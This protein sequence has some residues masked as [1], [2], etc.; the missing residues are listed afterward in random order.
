M[1]RR[2]WR[3]RLATGLLLALGLATP[4]AAQN[5]GPTVTN[6][7]TLAQTVSVGG[8]LQLAPAQPVETFQQMDLTADTGYE[9]N[10]TG[11][12]NS[13]GDWLETLAGNFAAGQNRGA[14]HWALRYQPSYTVYRTFRGYDRFDQAGALD[15]SWQLSP[16][17]Y[18]R[19]SEHAAYGRYLA[20]PQ[21][22]QVSGSVVALNNF[23]ATPFSRQ[24]SQQPTVEL[25]YVANYRWALHLSA[26]YLESRYF[27]QASTTG[28]ALSDLE[29]VTGSAGLS[30][31]LSRRTTLGAELDY[32]NMRLAG[33]IS[34]AQV[35]SAFLQLTRVLGPTAQ[36]TL[37]AGPQ[38]AELRENLTSYLPATLL[39]SNPGLA[40]IHQNN[41]GWT[42]G[43]TL[44]VQSYHTAWNLTVARRATDSGGLFA[45]AVEADQAT[46]GAMRQ[47]G[48]EWT[49]SGNAGFERITP[50]GLTLPGGNS[51]LFSWIAGARMRRG[52]GRHWALTGEYNYVD[53]T[54]QGAVPF[55]ARVLGRQSVALGIG[56][57]LG[58]GPGG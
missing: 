39:A 24:F 28:P 2:T 18:L 45:G 38:E 30:Y 7:A 22:A 27:G 57:R 1:A 35:G 42:A 15:L 11:L 3:L 51:A 37:F 4:A 16:H 13:G 9:T 47:L 33:G 48:L 53:E 44:A 55:A 21:A 50:L 36:V 8:P 41:L 19:L 32:S 34:R 31:R 6:P 49:I 23:V 43:G 5:A 58:R 54:T 17:W 46:V 25:D 12:S 14:L 20:T 52:F 10:V 40:R 56:Y 26:G 29:G